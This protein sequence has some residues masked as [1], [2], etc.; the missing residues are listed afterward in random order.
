MKD[1]RDVP[2]C[3]R[4]PPKPLSSVQVCMVQT[5][6]LQ[7]SL[8]VILCRIMDN[9]SG[10]STPYEETKTNNGMIE[11]S[12]SLVEISKANLDIANTIYGMLFEDR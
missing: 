4:E 1:Y 3:D 10:N 7:Y 8:N 11:N 9:L 6:E 2:I 5:T 12:H